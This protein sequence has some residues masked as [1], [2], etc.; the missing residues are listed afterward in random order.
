MARGK[1]RTDD[2]VPKFYELLYPTKLALD[3]LGGSGTVQEIHDSVVGVLSLS[4]E[5]V[6]K[7]HSDNKMTALSYRLAW[8]RTY[9]KLSGFIESTTRGV[10]ALTERGKLLTEKACEEIPGVVRK[11]VAEKKVA[12]SNEQSG[13]KEEIDEEAWVDLL[14]SEVRSMKHD[15]FERLAMRVLRESGFSQVEV[16]GRTG[17]G[18]IDGVGI[19]RVNLLSFQVLFQCKRYQGSVG[20]GAI[21]DFRGAMQGRSDK[22]I[23]ITTGVFTSDARKEATR[24]GAP[25]I[26]LIDG[27]A[28]CYLLKEKKLGVEVEQR[29]IVTVKKGF[30]DDA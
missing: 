21:R 16:T 8:A 14:L 26:D 27:E 11:L 29:E 20:S 6:D 5:V 19:L 10:W 25:A 9:L 22:G 4:S 28:F 1:R 12:T 30:F 17:D 2:L 7:V 3:K 15:A 23:V 18:G 24:D 13:P